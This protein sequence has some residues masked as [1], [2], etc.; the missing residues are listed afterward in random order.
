MSKY[1]VATESTSW[2][3]Q[4]LI[5]L[6][7]VR[8]VL[9]YEEPAGNVLRDGIRRHRHRN[10]HWRRNTRRGAQIYP[11]L[12]SGQKFLFWVRILFEYQITPSF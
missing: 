11:R 7:L 2:G 1:P 8:A 6:L 9:R 3:N 12:Q 10:D 4:T 5:P